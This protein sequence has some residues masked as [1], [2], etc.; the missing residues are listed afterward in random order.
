MS[1]TLLALFI[2]ACFALNTAPGPNNLL[3]FANGSK[4]GFGAAVIGGMGRLVPFAAMIALVGLGLGAI[5]ATSAAAFT[6]V[7]YAGAAYLAYVGW[8]MWCA[9]QP[10]TGEAG[11]QQSLP[12]LMR[13]DFLIAIGN[14]KA[15]A[16]FTAFFPQFTDLIQPLAP[17]YILLGALF[18]ALE[19]LAVTLYA[20][21]GAGM[22]GALT[23]TRLHRLN[24][25]VGGF[26][27]FSGLTMALS[28][29]P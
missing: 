3:A 14:P 27:I 2:P 25:G 28:E 15:I 13:R 10:D 11:A 6:V 8:R 1:F 22:K 21:L 18:L 17:Q 7:K 26:L 4:H 5:L 12:D 29:R 23:P 16:I 20:G 9:P 19:L 24:R